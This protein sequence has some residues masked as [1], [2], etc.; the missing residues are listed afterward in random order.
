MVKTALR[1][2]GYEFELGGTVKD[3]YGVSHVVDLVA[4]VPGQRAVGFIQ[5]Q[6]T[7]VIQLAGDWW[8]SK[9][10]EQEFLDS[11]KCNY[12]REQVLET[13]EQQG[14]DLSK[15]REI[16]EPDGTVIFELPLDDAE[17]EA[18]VIGA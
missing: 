9:I 13:L 17:M 6:R 8:G 15:L 7:G 1:K 4:H 3:Y 10:R 2:L 12:A 11:L 14:I 5:D 16:E 18:L